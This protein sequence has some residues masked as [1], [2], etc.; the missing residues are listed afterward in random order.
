VQSGKTSVQGIFDIV[1]AQGFPCVHQQAT[2]YFRFEFDQ[3][4]TDAIDVSLA[5]TS[6]SGLRNTS[7]STRLGIPAGAERAEGFIIVQGLL[8]NEAGKHSFE[9]LVNGVAVGHYALTAQPVGQSS[10]SGTTRVLN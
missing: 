3:S 6:P 5:I 10:E 4:P 8:F 9:L 1:W 7:P 2:A